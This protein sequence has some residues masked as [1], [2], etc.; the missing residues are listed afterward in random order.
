MITSEVIEHVQENASTTYIEKL[1]GI[2]ENLAM[3]SPYASKVGYQDV[4]IW[5]THVELEINKVKKGLS[6]V[7]FREALEDPLAERLPAPALALPFNCFMSSQSMTDIKLSCYYP[8][9]IAKIKYRP[10]SSNVTKTYEIPIPNIVITHEL[11]KDDKFWVV[12]NSKY[13]CTNKTVT[14]LPDLEFITR[15]DP[16]KGIYPIPLPNFYTEGRMCYGG[17][18]MP[19][20]MTNNLRGLDYYYQILT[21]SPFNDDLGIRGT[22]KSFSPGNWLEELSKKTTFDFSEMAD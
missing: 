14:Q 2:V 8:E 11:S 15:N 20:R 16:S 6:L 22:K 5:S 10:R 18:T 21:L 17:N 12:K 13:F 7:D 1:N 9:R 4:R 19:V 3:H